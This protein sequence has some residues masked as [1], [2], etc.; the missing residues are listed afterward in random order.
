M[1]PQRVLI[2]E[3]EQVIAFDLKMVL[4]ESGFEVLELVTSAEAAVEFALKEKPDA[5][6]MDIQLDGKKSGIDAAREILR[7]LIVPIIFHT[8][9]KEI[10]YSSDLSKNTL[11][12]VI[13]KPISEILLIKTIQSLI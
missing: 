8:A 5:V 7:E 6:L 12:T 11:C 1:K 3:D 2:V 13:S 10:Y 9:N 4:E